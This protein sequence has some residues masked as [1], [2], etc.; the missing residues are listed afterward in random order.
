MF[1]VAFLVLMTTLTVS[2]QFPNGWN[3]SP[4]LSYPYT[5]QQV[6]DVRASHGSARAKRSI[7]DT[8]EVKAATIDHYLAYI[9]A[10]AANGV[11]ANLLPA[12]YASVM[13][14]GAAQQFQVT[15]GV[16]AQALATTGV[17]NAQPIPL[18][19]QNLANSVAAATNGLLFNLPNLFPQVN[20]NAPAQFVQDTPEV[21]EAKL[22]FFRAFYESF[23]RSS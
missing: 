13:P 7:E 8:P 14:W 20:W 11:T 23:F 3:Y 1:A 18:A 21:L 19:N 17:V 4:L 6:A 2:T 16:A 9:A 22:A 12:R 10:A 5:G 15:P